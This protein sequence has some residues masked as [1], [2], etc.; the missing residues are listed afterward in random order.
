MAV[1]KADKNENDLTQ[2]DDKDRRKRKNL[3]QKADISTRLGK[4]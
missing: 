1:V 2:K 3:N 4:P